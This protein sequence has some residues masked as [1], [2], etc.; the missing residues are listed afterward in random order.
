MTEFNIPENWDIMSPVRQP[1]E[2]FADYKERMRLLK[3]FDKIVKNGEFYAY[4]RESG[5]DNQSPVSPRHD[6]QNN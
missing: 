5:L 2:D 3:R 1:G 4:L 6:Q